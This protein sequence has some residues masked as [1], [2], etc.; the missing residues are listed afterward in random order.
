[1]AVAVTVGSHPLRGQ[2]PADHTDPEAKRLVKAATASLPSGDDARGEALVSGKGACLSC[3]QVGARG[4]RLGPDLSEIGVVRT[5]PELYESLV[6]PAALVLPEGR[7]FKVVTREGVSVTGRLMNLDTYT[8]LLMDSKEQLRS[9]DKA[10]LREYSFVK[11]STMP[12]YRATLT[13]QELADVIAYL[14]TLKGT[15]E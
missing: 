1:M 7:F 9:F 13:S 12:S 11:G 8:V 10:S 14:G 6:N 5:A 2:Q 3:H 15:S 4:S